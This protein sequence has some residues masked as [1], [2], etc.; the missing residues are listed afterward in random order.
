MSSPSVIAKATGLRDTISRGDA[1]LAILR[2]QLMPVI[3]AILSERL[4]GLVRQLPAVDFAQ[5]V[6]DDLEELRLRGF[7]LPRS[8]GDYIADWV[9]LGILV[10]DNSGRDE[11]VELSPSAQV[12]VRFVATLDTH[13][14]SVTRSRLANVTDLL[15]KLVRDSDAEQEGRLAALRAEQQA[16]AKQIAQVE[17]GEYSPIDTDEALERLAEVLRLASEIPGD[18][19]QVSS[20]L[21]AIN[22]GLREK[23]INTVGSRGDVLDAV[24]AGVDLIDTSEAGRSFGAFNALLADQQRSEELEDSIG[25]VLSRDFAVALDDREKTFLADFMAALEGESAHV[26]ATMTGF[27]R[28]LRS[29]VQSRAYEEHRVLQDALAR[30]QADT[31]EAAKHV[32]L[33]THMHYE[34]PSASVALAS[35]GT[36]RLYNPGD[37]RTAAPVVAQ[38]VGTLDIEALRARVRLSEIDFSELKRSV[39]DVVSRRGASSVGDVLDAHPAT[40]GLASVVGLLS[41]AASTGRQQGGI[42]RLAWRSNSGAAR[43]VTAHRYVFM[44]VPG[45]WARKTQRREAPRN[46]KEP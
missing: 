38:Q 33:T 21:R 24:F 40:Q 39:A 26:R 22:A 17:A 45:S 4:G 2:A 25:Q 28:S 42:E 36:W 32:K 34:L 1:G 44:S 5:Q 29:F 8:A 23:I 46:T 30:V 3:V 35:V 27:S 12:V 14:R 19:A 10:R 31:L 7:D 13:G 41:L 15:A 9:R 11:T 18:F 20:D 43:S 37:V 16:I 6:A